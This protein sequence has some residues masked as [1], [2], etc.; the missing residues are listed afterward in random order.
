MNFRYVIS[1]S[2]GEV[3]NS[4]GCHTLSQAKEIAEGIALWCRSVL[5]KKAVIIIN[6]T[7]TKKSEIFKYL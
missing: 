4:V 6:D 5:N 1:Y 2:Y 3:G 7:E